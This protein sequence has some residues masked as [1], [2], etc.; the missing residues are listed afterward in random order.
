MNVLNPIAYVKL[1]RTIFEGMVGM[2]GVMTDEVAIEV[3]SGGLHCFLSDKDHFAMASVNIPREALLSCDVQGEKAVVSFDKRRYGLFMDATGG[4]EIVE[5]Y[6]YAVKDASNVLSYRTVLMANGVEVPIWIENLAPGEPKMPTLE[7]PV[8][9]EVKVED[10]RRALKLI[11]EVA[12]F[13]VMRIDNGEL[14]V[15]SSHDYV[16]GTGGYSHTEGAR[17]TLKDVI[18]D[19]DDDA[20]SS[21]L[22]HYIAELFKVVPTEK[23]T[24][25][26]GSEF[27]ISIEYDIGKGALVD[28]VHGQ[29]TED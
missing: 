24:M 18:I 17:V 27:P 19:G 15:H 22:L 26:L 12:P 9:V 21:F 5:M 11:E 25:F 6:I 23:C 20:A 10:M 3:S 13:A 28:F 1:D 4:S 29:G 14:V 7:W 16:K 2:L 8:S